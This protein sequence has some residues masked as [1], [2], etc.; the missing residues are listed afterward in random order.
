MRECESRCDLICKQLHVGI[1]AVRQTKV[2]YRINP[3]V[4]MYHSRKLQGR[5]LQEKIK[6][7]VIKNLAV[8]VINLDDN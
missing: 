8:V 2:R 7:S 5:F 6:V 1:D 3:H 4:Y